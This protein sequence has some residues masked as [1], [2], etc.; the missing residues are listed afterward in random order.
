MKLLSNS[1]LDIARE[2]GKTIQDS[3]EYI[4][5]IKSQ[6]EYY[7][8]SN[9]MKLKSK[10]DEKTKLYNKLLVEGQ[11]TDIKNISLEI[12]ELNKKL[13]K[14][15]KYTNYIKCKSK[16]EKTIKNVDNILEYYTGISNSKGC[17]GCKK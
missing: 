3:E 9:T 10:L 8:D 6:E 2:L 13:L 11:K 4:E 5:Y 14:E 17:N 15:K 1:T 12:K 7:N 16:V